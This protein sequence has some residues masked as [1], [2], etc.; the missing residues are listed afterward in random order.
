MKKVIK[1]EE[2][3]EKM[4][5]AIDLLCDTVK[6]TLGPKGSNAII[7]HSLFSPFITNDGV[8]IARNI[9]SDDEEIN[10]ILQLAKESSIKTDETVADG[11]TSCLVLLQSI[12]KEGLKYLEEGLKPINL[13]NELNNALANVLAYL[14]SLAWQPQKE[15]I[16]KIALTASKNEQVASLVTEAYLKIPNKKALIV[17]EVEE[18]TS[19]LV[20]KNGYIVEALWASSYY[21]IKEKELKINE[22]YLLI[23]ANTLYALDDIDAIINEVIKTK[24]DLLIIADDYSQDFINEIVSLYLEEKI[25]IYLVKCPGYGLEKINIQNDLALIANSLVVSNLSDLQFTSLG[26]INAIL[27]EDDLTF[28]FT[29]NS[30]KEEDLKRLALLSYGVGYIKV[31]A[32]T[33]TERRELK[34]HFDDALGAVFASLNGV[35]LGSGLSLLKTSNYLN[36]DTVGNKIFKKVLPTCFKQIMQNAGENEEK[37][38]AQAIKNDFKK[39]YNVNNKKWEDINA[40]SVLDSLDVVIS[41]LSN[42]VSIASM[43]LTTTSLIINEQSNNLEKT[44]SYTEL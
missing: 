40:T 38:L 10:T 5:I 37:L 2:L 8:T 42:A 34:M 1:D 16:K 30:Y 41:S 19:S 24:K 27:T 13:K 7:D 15:E 3:K 22:G 14:K 28:N 39:V 18:K 33:L 23:Y 17:K 25:K 9:E 21:F 4:K 20:I 35:V 44:V 12:Y 43:L 26:L 32:P 36:D 31:G 29:K 6:T 11:T